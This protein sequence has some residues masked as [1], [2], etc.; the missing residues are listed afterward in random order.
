MR[1]VIAFVLCSACFPQTGAPPPQPVRAVTD[2]GVVTTRQSITPAGIP[3]VFQGRVYGAAFGADS[4]DLYVL[5]ATHV[6]RLDWK[7]NRVVES[8]AHGGSP[9]LQ[10]IRFDGVNGQALFSAARPGTG[11]RNGPRR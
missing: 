8:V 1:L 9:G 11:G 7:A 6:Y 5:H 2:P 4:S 3:T 10:G